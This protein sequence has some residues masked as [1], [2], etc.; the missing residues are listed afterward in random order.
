VTTAGTDGLT[1]VTPA[2]TAT[3]FATPTASSGP[4]GIAV[5][6]SGD[7]GFTEST[8]HKIGRFAPYYDS[9]A[10]T[11]Y[12]VTAGR[13]PFGIAAGADGNMWITERDGNR[14]GRVTSA[15]VVTEFAVPT[16]N[17]APTSI[18]TGPDGAVW[19]TE[20]GADKIGRYALGLTT[21][22]TDTTAV[23]GQHY[24]YR[25]SAFYESWTSPQG[26]T[27]MSLSM[28]GTSGS[29]ATDLT[30][31]A[32]ALTAGEVSALA[33]ADN[34][35]YTTRS[36]WVASATSDK[37]FQD[38]ESRDPD[39]VWAVGDSGTIM[40]ST[41]GGALW[42]A[43]TSGTTQHLQG[44][45]F[46]DDNTGWAVGDGGTIVA[47]ADGGVTWTAQSS[48]TSTNLQ[49]VTFASATAGWA[50]G[51]GGRIRYWNG[52]SWSGQTSPTTDNLYGVT[53]VSDSLVWAVGDNGRILRYNGTSWSNLATPTAFG[54]KDVEALDATRAWAVGNSGAVVAY[55]GSS[56]TAQTSST[57]EHLHGLAVI[58]ASAVW[59]SGDAGTLR[60][61]NGT[62]WLTRTSGTSAQL[63]E[64]SFA[65][66]SKGYFVGS[67]GLQR[68]TVDGGA[69]WTVS[70]VTRTFEVVIPPASVASGAAAGRVRA[71]FVYRTSATPASGAQFDVRASFDG[72][73]SWTRRT[74]SR[75]TS[76]ATVTQTLDFTSGLSDPA[77]LQTHGVRLRFEIA[78][79]NSFTTTHDM[80][81]V[82]VN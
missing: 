17:S 38:V 81:R 6:P 74:L 39:R 48:G 26:G 75:P 33:R 37:N 11:E 14:I 67:A 32:V 65:N 8:G 1:R 20:R 60:Y 15:G 30:V 53:A 36:T 12:S 79:T 16:A 18:A 10:A 71:T 3:G 22:F 42:T 72:G 35:T 70:P 52:T 24:Y 66:A 62:S 78:A 29:D 25:A 55:N 64:V 45:H 54:L 7:L 50:V 46:V 21:S 51:D 63:K 61:F 23:A 47:T 13:A 19:F 27:A 73:A 59:A 44:A 28:S 2:G 77:N 41:D 43:R 4:T 68:R 80:V 82:D 34:A 49:D 69:T 56:W 40:V 76:T 57:T 5:G 9:F 31:P 58:S